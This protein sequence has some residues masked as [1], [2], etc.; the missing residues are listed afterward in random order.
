MKCVGT[1][2]LESKDKSHVE[3]LRESDLLDF[4]EHLPV[5][6]FRST[7]SGRLKMVNNALVALLGFD[8]IDDILNVTV[9]DLYADPDLRGRLV[10]R[11]ADGEA[12]PPHDVELRRKDG[13]I[14]M[15]RV[16]A[17]S[18]L[19]AD[20][21]TL[22]ME[23]VL[24]D[25]TERAQIEAALGASEELFTSAFQ[26]APQ[27][28]AIVGPDLVLRKVNAALCTMLGASE[29]E[30]LIGSSERFLHPEELPD[31][32]GLMTEMRS[33]VIDSYEVE[34]RL[35]HADGHF[36]RTL[37]ATS[38]VRSPNGALR[39]IVSQVFDV[40]ERVKAQ[41]EL[42]DS[43][44]LFRG[45]FDDAPTGMVITGDGFRISRANPAI[46]R[47]LGMTESVLQGLMLSDLWDLSTGDLEVLNDASDSEMT[48]ELG[49]RK[50]ALLRE[51]ELWALVS[52]SRVKGPGDQPSLLAQLVD[53]TK[54]HEASAA[55]E[56]TEAE[57]SAL[58]D[59]IPDMMLRVDRSGE[60][61]SFRP[62]GAGDATPAQS[63]SI[64]STVSELFPG[65]AAPLME[66]VEEVL[67]HGGPVNL[68]FMLSQPQPDRFFTATVSRIDAAH[69]LVTVREVTEQKLVQQ[70]LE[71]LLK[72]KDDLVASVSHELRNPL[73]A[74]VGLATELSANSEMF[75]AEERQEFIR[76]I[77][78]QSS[79]MA[80]LIDDLLVAARA[81][82]GRVTVEP[83][84]IDIAREVDQVLSVWTGDAAQVDIEQD[85]R[86]HADPFRVRQILRNLLSNANRYGTPPVRIS[87]SNADDETVELVIQDHGTGLSPDEWE[88]IFDPYHQA[89]SGRRVPNSVGLGLAV[90]RHLAEV[91][92]GNLE[93]LVLNDLSTFRLSLPTRPPE[94]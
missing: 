54:R 44:A 38:A 60:L 25:V 46:C 55:L 4:I 67:D 49:E 53:V 68:E 57:N 92:G 45:T 20:G 14:V 11:L 77:V 32:M 1:N 9:A 39:A 82:Q 75:A 33:G 84:I 50:L 48:Y 41:R 63:H 80:D 7:P 31:A 73:T 40:S 88:P 10:T 5:A 56:R 90:S 58:L 61:H 74:I 21:A 22:F 69:A 43:E 12:I 65:S 30:L 52:V 93:Y 51:R 86:A 34:R 16:T 72:S 87:V 26:H 70:Q 29:S 13:T 83:R 91:M 59:A 76:L 18:V 62:A 47:M 79:E 64:H 27:G 81:E 23:G 85:V 17:R 89:T 3:M 35:R 28:L 15:V 37:I 71:S 78:D 94:V 2:A 66:H 24:E 36:L 8:S 6:A 42:A 19:G